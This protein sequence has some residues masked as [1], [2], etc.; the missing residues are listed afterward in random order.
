MSSSR[1]CPVSLAGLVQLRGRGNAPNFASFSPWIVRVN[2]LLLIA[3][4][5]L[6]ANAKLTILLLYIRVP[7]LYYELQNVQ[8][9]VM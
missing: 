3:M 7:H 6:V 9:I 8:V 1:F 2:V 4:I 5:Q